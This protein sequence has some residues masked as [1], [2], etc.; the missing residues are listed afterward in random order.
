MRPGLT[1]AAVAMLGTIVVTSEALAAMPLVPRDRLLAEGAN[2]S[3]IELVQG[4]RC[5]MWRRECSVRWGFRTPRYHR[6][7]GRNGC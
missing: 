2:G 6:C 3:M 7:M 1:I 5:R 4:G